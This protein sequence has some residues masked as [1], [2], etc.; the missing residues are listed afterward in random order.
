MYS[1][2]QL[3]KMKITKEEL[4]KNESDFD[5]A[6]PQTFINDIIK[7]TDIDYQLLRS[8]TVWSYKKNRFGEPLSLCTEIQEKLDK[9]YKEL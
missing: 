3:N 5:Y 9:I 7:N 2:T 6:L 4:F 1:I 8:T